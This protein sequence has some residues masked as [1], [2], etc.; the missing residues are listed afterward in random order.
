MEV[1]VTTFETNDGTKAEVNFAKEGTSP[2][3][4]TLEVCR[5]NGLSLN[6][7]ETYDATE[8]FFGRQCVDLDLQ[9]MNVVYTGIYVDGYVDE[10]GQLYE[11][12]EPVCP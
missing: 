5:R 6:Q 8:S 3:S 7:A 9:G 11:E 10:D 12:G 4:T 2:L 1:H